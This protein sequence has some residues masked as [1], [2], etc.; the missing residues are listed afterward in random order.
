MTR[1]PGMSRSRSSTPTGISTV[2]PVK[3]LY[4]RP[5]IPTPLRKCVMDHLHGGCQGATAMFERAS[6]TFYW[7]N[8][9]IELINHTAACTICAKYQPS[10][11]AMPP[12]TPDEP[13][14]PF[15]SIRADFFTIPPHT[16]LA[17]VF[18]SR[19]MEAFFHKFGIIHR[20]STAY[21]PRAN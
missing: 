5:A 2:G 4:G 15:R 3:M 1:M 13:S 7:P 16:Y 12:V 17:K 19:E 10:N 11:P 9:G 6:S 20:A 21:H 8:F 18:T 14:Y